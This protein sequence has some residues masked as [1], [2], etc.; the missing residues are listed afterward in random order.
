MPAYPPARWRRCRRHA[1]APSFLVR[2]TGSDDEGG[3]ALADFTI[4]VSDNDGPFVAWLEHTTLTEATY[5]GE[6]GH[7]YA[8]YSVA[9]D[10]AGNRE[11][12]P[13]TPDTTVIAPPAA[14]II[15]T[16]TAGLV[17]TEAGGA[18]GFTVV[19]NAQPT[20]DVTIALS[21]G[22]TSEGTV[23]P[24]S[25][26]FTPANWAVPQT[27]TVTG[28]DDDLVDGHTAYIVS[29]AAATSADPDYDG[30]NAAD[31]AV[32]NRDNEVAGTTLE[33]SAAAP[34]PA[35]VAI[36]FNMPFDALALNLY[37]TESAN[38]GPADVL[39]VGA[40]A[41]AVAGSLIVAPDAR[42]VTFLK[43]GGPLV[44]DTYTLT[45]RSAADGFRDASG[46][47]LDGDGDGIAG[48]DHVLTFVVAA[49]ADRMLSVP[50][51]ARGPGQPVDLPATGAG[52]PIR[53]DDG[54]GVTSA[55][56]V[57]AYDPRLLVITSAVVGSGLPNGATVTLDLSAPPGWPS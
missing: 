12:A 17:T 19:L 15:I 29:T 53:L 30:L 16:P 46:G 51:F 24:A 23:S 34:T 1:D 36:A 27:V 31:V 25:L 7:T 57:L 5:L 8:F 48:G 35:G 28:V 2:W 47:L 54:A 52:L 43:T 20:A 39:L 26:T 11:P 33:V 14:G 38:L 41:G 6:R 44:A 40:S 45:L 50:D 18:A 3:S 56:L 37:D 4:Y 49:S 32:T 22:D 21:S 55:R 13:P 42:S 10:N 9:P